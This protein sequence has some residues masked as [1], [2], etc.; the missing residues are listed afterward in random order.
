[1]ETVASGKQ[2]EAILAEAL[3][4]ASGALRRE[5][6]RCAD[7]AARVSREAAG[8]IRDATQLRENWYA[9]ARGNG[10]G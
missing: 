7:I 9:L 4:E 10:L 1:L 3:L 8:A 5:S 2:P 6:I